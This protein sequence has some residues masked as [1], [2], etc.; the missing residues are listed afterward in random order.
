[1]NILSQRFDP[2]VWRHKHPDHN[3]SF[4]DAISVKEKHMNTALGR[5]I[6]I[7]AL[8]VTLLLLDSSGVVA[9][10]RTV[11][12]DGNYFFHSILICRDGLT[13]GIYGETVGRPAK[14]TLTREGET[15]GE[16]A[17]TQTYHAVPLLAPGQDAEGPNEEFSIYATAIMRG[18]SLFDVGQRLVLRVE[19]F[20]SDGFSVSRTFDDELMVVQDCLL[21]PSLPFA[22]QGRLTD[23]HGA[24]SGAYDFKFSLYDA[25]QQGNQLRPTLEKTGIAVVDG[26]FTTEL[27]FGF[28]FNGAPRWLAIEVRRAGS[29]DYEPLSPRQALHPTPQAQSAPWHGLTG[30]PSGFSDGVDN[31]S[32]ASLGVDCAR[33]EGDQIPVWSKA[34]SSWVCRD[35]PIAAENNTIAVNAVAGRIDSGGSGGVHS[36]DKR[37]KVGHND[38][39]FVTGNFASPGADFAELLPAAPDLEPGDVL[40]IAPT[41][42]LIQSDSPHA[43]NVAGIFSTQPGFVGG[44]GND[45]IHKIPLALVGIVPTKVSAEN[46]P[47][48]PGDL[49][50]TSSTPGHAMKASPLVV[51]GVAFHAPGTIIGK[52]LEPLESG[53]GVLDVLVS[54]Q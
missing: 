26:L 16:I 6:L 32:L 21:N 46:G 13:V 47:I 9:K 42:I 29:G 36:F 49:L 28:V 11:F 41:G 50:T 33:G 27:D 39:V 43:V 18:P 22:Y 19:S 31:D 52:A 14:F 1:M 10:R 34:E 38:N 3:K 30:V 48:R 37:F 17:L 8:L 51:N 25:A 24:V 44:A 35:V 12:D 53:T 54:L 2:V 4:W 20:D 40:V 45:E 23:A 7:G 5:S 15:I